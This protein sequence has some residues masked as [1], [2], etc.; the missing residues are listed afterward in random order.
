MTELLSAGVV[1]FIGLALAS[2]VAPLIVLFI[3]LATYK[4]FDYEE[5]LRKNMRGK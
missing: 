1:V 4:P 2:V 5:A 3:E